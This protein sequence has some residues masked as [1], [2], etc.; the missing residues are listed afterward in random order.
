M[1]PLKYYLHLILIRLY[2]YISLLFGV[3]PMFLLFLSISKRTAVSLFEEFT[4]L[5]I[6]A[7]RYTVRD[8]TTILFSIPYFD[9]RKNT[10][11][12]TY[13]KN[14]TKHEKFTFPVKSLKN[15]Y[16]QINL[17]H[18]IDS[19]FSPLYLIKPIMDEK[20]MKSRFC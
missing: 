8:H 13:Q 12:V 7:H 19:I 10:E 3:V 5:S 18:T 11:T 20:H 9:I 14:T 15:S 16:I 17:L 2:I 1:K 6:N 4:C